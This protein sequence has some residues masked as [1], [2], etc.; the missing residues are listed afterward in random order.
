MCPM[1][2]RCFL[3]VARPLVLRGE[4]GLY[5]ENRERA[6]YGGLVEYSRDIHVIMQASQ[7]NEI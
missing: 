2:C 7:H 4:G 3:F 1:A 5:I 6:G